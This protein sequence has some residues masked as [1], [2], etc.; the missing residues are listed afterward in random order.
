MPSPRLL[1]HEE[2]SSHRNAGPMR[3]GRTASTTSA[4]E[5]GTLRNR[6]SLL[7]DISRPRHGSRSTRASHARNPVGPASG[8]LPS[9]SS[10]SSA[11]GSSLASGYGVPL[12]LQTTSSVVLPERAG[13]RVHVLVL[14]QHHREVAERDH[15]RP[16]A[17]AR[18]AAGSGRAPSRVVPLGGRIQLAVVGVH[19]QP[20]RPG[21]EPGVL[22][23]SH[24]TGVRA[25]S[26]LI[27]RSAARTAAGS[28]PAT[29]A[30]PK[31]LTDSMSR[32]S[33]T[34]ANG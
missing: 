17:A 27:R 3:A 31:W 15:R 32:K 13:V 2:P 8:R 9:T 26:R 28:S 1:T 4:H 24:C 34:E 19:R 23:A 18:S 10:A 33:S 14:G 12:T 11:S 25:L 30:A 5:D 29:I 21:G 20:R 6:S 7:D 16:R 22:G